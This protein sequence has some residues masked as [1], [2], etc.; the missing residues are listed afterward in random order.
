MKKILFSFLTAMCTLMFFNSCGKSANT[1]SAESILEISQEYSV[2][3]SAYGTSQSEENCEAYKNV[4]EKYIDII[5]S[6]PDVSQDDI[7]EFRK[8]LSE[9]E[10]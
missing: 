7:V 2:A 6:C 3:I 10:C 1:C 5:E 9:L 4:L 8:E